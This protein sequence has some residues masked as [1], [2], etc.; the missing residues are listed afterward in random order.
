[1]A[2][3]TIRW[4]ARTG[5]LASTKAENGRV[6]IPVSEIDRIMRSGSET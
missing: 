1:V 4:W 6:R 5:H 3:G 2:P